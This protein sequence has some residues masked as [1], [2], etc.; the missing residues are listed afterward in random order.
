MLFRSKSHAFIPTGEAIV[1][2]VQRLLTFF[3]DEGLP[4]VFT[5]FAVQKGEPDPI[6]NW[7]GDSVSEG[8]KESE[9]V[10]ELKPQAQEKVLR[11]T[12]YDS[13]HGTD[14]EQYLKSHNVR[15]VIIT[16]VL[17]NL[18]CEMAARESFTRGFSTFFAMD[19]T[20]TFNEDL[21]LTSLINIASGFATPLTTEEVLNHN[22]T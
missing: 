21:H 6:R 11:K 4:I 18:C 15:D 7:W 12:S 3:R 8:S 16:G 22:A 10:E 13:F 1:P 5:R 20:A 9:V 17:T 14:L 19:A 2:N